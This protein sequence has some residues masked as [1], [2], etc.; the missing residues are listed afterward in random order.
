MSIKPLLEMKILP[1]SD[2]IHFNKAT[3][4][5]HGGNFVPPGNFLNENSL[6][7]L[8]EAV[9]GELLGQAMYPTLADKAAFYMF[10]IVTGHIFQD[11]NKRTGLGAARYFLWMNGIKMGQD[12]VQIKNQSGQ[13]IPEN[14]GDFKGVLYNFTLEMASGK[15]TLDE[16]RQW[17]A[18]NT[19]A[20]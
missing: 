8:L 16:A 1:K 18:V 10:S 11:G 3:V 20:K 13:L 14:G 2:I 19:Q 12:L 17:F 6:D 5:E 4:E 15:I 7:Y 9:N